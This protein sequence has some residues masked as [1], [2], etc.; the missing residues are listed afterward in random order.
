MLNYSD[1]QSILDEIDKL[2]WLA[3]TTNTPEAL[4]YMTDTMFTAQNGDRS[5]IPN[6][7][8]VITGKD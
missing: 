3:Q 1:K 2:E 5:D 4:R 8:I 7:A 6:A